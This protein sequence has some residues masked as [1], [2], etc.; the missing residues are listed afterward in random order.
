MPKK[1]IPGVICVENMTLFLL[2]FIMLILGFMYF[3]FAKREST[4]QN[5]PIIISTPMN[6]P[7]RATISPLASISTRDT[8]FN[9]PYAPP[10]KTDGYYTGGIVD[11]RGPPV[12]VAPRVMSVGY[13]QMGILTRRNGRED[14]ILPLMGRRALN[15]RDKWQ[16]YTISNTGTLNTKLP[17]SSNGKSC[18]GDNGCD[19]INNNDSVYVEG[20]KD[21]FIATIYETGTYSYNP[22]I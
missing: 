12:V 6:V 9:D 10:L 22:I 13:S 8:D 15:R 18:T 4:R 16:Y 21:T 17:V 1:C 5:S 7:P 2:F 19:E 20:Y 14:M 11:V 3:N